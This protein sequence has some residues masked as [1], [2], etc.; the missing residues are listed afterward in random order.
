MKA[1]EKFVVRNRKLENVCQTLLNPMK[2]TR[3]VILSLGAWAAVLVA[4]CGSFPVGCGPGYQVDPNVIAVDPPYG[5]ENHD[6]LEAGS[7]LFGGNRET[8]RK[9]RAI[10]TLL[11]V[12]GQ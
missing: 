3:F 1:R 4:G 7:I 2:K 12:L 10:G 11:D 8:T 6:A 5:T 9:A